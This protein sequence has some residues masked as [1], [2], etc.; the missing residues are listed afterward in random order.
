MCW[1]YSARERSYHFEDAAVMWTQHSQVLPHP[2]C[3]TLQ[4]YAR[5]LG[6]RLSWVLLS[7]HNLSKA[8]WGEL[9]KTGSQLMI[10]HYGQ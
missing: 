4:S 8:A 7:S 1:S 5:F 6:Q 9:Q 10:R 3:P 2:S